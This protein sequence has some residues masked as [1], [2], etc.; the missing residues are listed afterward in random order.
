VPLVVVEEEGSCWV[1]SVGGA[2][3]VEDSTLRFLPLG[4]ITDYIVAGE[5]KR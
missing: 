1:E 2:S 3:V 5:W 4:G